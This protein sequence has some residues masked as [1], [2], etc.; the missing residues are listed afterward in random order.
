MFACASLLRPL[1]K[2]LMRNPYLTVS[3]G[4][5][6]RAD[7]PRVASAVEAAPGRW[8]HHVVLGSPDEVDDELMALV[9]EAAA[10]SARKR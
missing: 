4:L 2:P 1:R 7:S 5:A 8:T 3:I 10:F 9:R 6:H